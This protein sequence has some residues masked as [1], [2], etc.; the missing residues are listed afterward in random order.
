[1]GRQ[2]AF[3]AALHEAAL[4]SETGA[5]EISYVVWVRPRPA[6]RRIRHRLMTVVRLLVS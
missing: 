4:G 3:H 2:F 1:M 6:I 5:I